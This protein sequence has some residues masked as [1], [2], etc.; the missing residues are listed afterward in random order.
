MDE[1]SNPF[2]GETEGKRDSH[3]TGCAGE[4]GMTKS[5]SYCGAGVAYNAGIAG[6][7]ESVLH[8]TTCEPELSKWHDSLVLLAIEVAS[9]ALE[10]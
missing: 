2:P 1:T 6:T 9:A 8:V 5:N 10:L 4:V 3:G 7:F